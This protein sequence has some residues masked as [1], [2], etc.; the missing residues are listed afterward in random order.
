[1]NPILTM[2]LLSFLP[3]SELRGGIPYGYFL[4]IPLHITIPVCIL[5]N[6]C[7]PLV[8]D[9]FINTLHRLF[10]HLGWYRTLFTRF[11][12]NARR[13]VEPKVDK[14]GFWGLMLFVA[15]PL[16]VTGAWTASVAAW[17]L[18]IE[19]KKSYPA[20]L[21]GILIASAIVT[22]VLLTG[23]GIFSIFIKSFS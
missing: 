23:A 5:A 10:F 9:L 12:E 2:I 3:V 7:V 20:I 6:C 4:D 16:P 18:N 15:I 22:T 19:R 14:Y 11:V 21:L 8:A 17:V 1:M 13:K